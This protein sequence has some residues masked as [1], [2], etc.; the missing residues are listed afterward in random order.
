MYKEILFLRL[1]L[2]CYSYGITARSNAGPLPPLSIW[3]RRG[4]FGGVPAVVDSRVTGRVRE[5]AS[6]VSRAFETST[7]TPAAAAAWR[8]PGEKRRAAVRRRRRAKR[9]KMRTEKRNNGRGAHTH[10]HLCSV[11]RCALCS[12]VSYPIVRAAVQA[13]TAALALKRKKKQDKTYRGRPN[14]AAR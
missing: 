6:P 11:S 12:A 14:A 7:E 2:E 8:P 5:R 1:V 9:M 3:P 4:L 13:A 10:G